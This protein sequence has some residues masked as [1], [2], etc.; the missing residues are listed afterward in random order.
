MATRDP[1]RPLEPL[2]ADR[3]LR[4]ETMS[5]DLRFGTTITTTTTNN[6][7]NNLRASE[8]DLILA[9]QQIPMSAGNK[10]ASAA[11]QKKLQSHH[12]SHQQLAG[13]G[14]ERPLPAGQLH[15]SH[16]HLQS[17]AGLQ[18]HPAGASLLLGSNGNNNHH[19]SSSNH[20][21]HHHSNHH[22]S[23]GHLHLGSAGQLAKQSAAGKSAA[24]SLMAAA[25][26]RQQQVD[27]SDSA[28]LPSSGSA[29]T[30]QSMFKRRHLG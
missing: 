5:G 10:S 27:R 25:A 1:T 14:A 23:Q 9:K 30:S 15:S 21:S 4:F 7:N 24:S 11:E 6:N 28:S 18:Q 26:A 13:S 16:Q 17:G 2:G 19:S 22:Q 8:Q 12:L 3:K 20:H 29:S